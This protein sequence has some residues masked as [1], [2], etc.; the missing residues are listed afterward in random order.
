LSN[1]DTFPGIGG[2]YPLSSI[3]TSE[4]ATTKWRG[5]MMGSVFA[6][7]GLGQLCAAVVM[8]VVTAGFKGSLLTASK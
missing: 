8:V 6:M 7:Q 1:I 3:I 4:F 2:D 5:A